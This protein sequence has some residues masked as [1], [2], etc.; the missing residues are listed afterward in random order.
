MTGA[1]TGHF[2]ET[3]DSIASMQNNLP[4]HKILFYDLG[5]KSAEV[6]QVSVLFDFCGKEYSRSFFYFIY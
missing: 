6:E 5:L 2:N 4:Q 3:R 1:D